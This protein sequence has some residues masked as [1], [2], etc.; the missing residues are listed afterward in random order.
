MSEQ[1]SLSFC[2]KI[3]FTGETSGL[4]IFDWDGTVC[5]SEA[6]IVRA[7]Q[8]AILEADM[9]SLPD[10]AVRN[11]IGLGLL[12]AVQSLFPSASRAQWETVVEAYSRH[13][14]AQEQNLPELFPNAMSVLTGLRDSG[15]KLAVATGKS[16]RGLNRI[17]DAL[18]L[19]DFFDATRT[20]DETRSKPHPQ[21]LR[22]LLSELN[23]SASQALMVGD[24][25]YDL[26][27]ATAIDMPCIGVSYGVHSVDQLRNSGA[28]AVIDGLDE[29]PAL[30]AA[31]SLA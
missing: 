8:N 3:P 19:A 26:D 18:D 22:E 21:M 25:T 5:D 2:P 10:A 12:E 31:C 9:P 30:V 27:M 11:I 16:R 14:I 20:A 1:P 6:H 29:L 13:Y 7:M 24:T 17:L 4:V 28:L 23:L 15:Y